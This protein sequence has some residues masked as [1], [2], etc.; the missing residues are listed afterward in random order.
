[1]K[2]MVLTLFIASTFLLSCSSDDDNS[3][4]RELNLSINGLEDLG[5]N[6]VYEGWVIVD[7]SPVS[8]G[9]FSVNSSGVLSNSSFVLDKE[10]LDAATTFVLTIEPSVG[11]DP[12]PSDVHILAGNFN[13]NSGDLSVSHSAALGNSFTNVTG[14][15]ILATPT[16]GGMM[17][18]EES[19]VWFLDNS[20]GSM[21]EGLNLPTLPAGWEYEGWAVINGSP[22]ST[23][24][25]SSVNMADSNA[26]TS[27][28]KGNANNGPNFPGE[29]FLQ[30]APL[31]LTFPTDL[32]GGTIVISVEPSPDNST[33]PFLLKPLVH[34]VPMSA[35]THAVLNMNQN[36]TSLPT[37]SFTR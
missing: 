22:V 13:G 1:M 36:L 11:D 18:N 27:P 2:K 3:T 28:F 6:Y 37:G 4:T 33:A 21:V 15:Y 31:G 9:R 34:S 19:G 24:R 20:S 7:G 14:K 32:R 12:A 10:T 26:A 8:T 29:D 17:D 35:T 25:F 16:D 5:S 23:G 30:N